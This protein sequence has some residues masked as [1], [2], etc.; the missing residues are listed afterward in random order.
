MSWR[1]AAASAIGTSHANAGIVCQD[2]V[3]A[4]VISTPGDIVFICAVSDGA[5][6]AQYA[7]VGSKTAVDTAIRLVET[8][9]KT[10]GAVSEATRELA[11]SWFA[12]V[13]RSILKMAEEFGSSIREFGCTLLVAIIAEE[14][15]AF[16]QVGDGA[17]V[18][19]DGINDN[20]S[21]IFWPQ[22]GEYANSTNFVTSSNFLAVMEFELVNRRIESFASF[23]DGIER[24][25]LHHATKSV[26]APFFNSM[27]IPVEQ[28]SAL[29]LSRS[30][31]ESLA[32]FLNSEAVCERTDD[33]KTLVLATRRVPIKQVSNDD[34]RA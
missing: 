15:A 23:S 19:A 16:I 11:A 27:L 2:S 1:I 31:S 5:G 22:H 14:F 9:L 3:G 25:V 30:G 32:K 7:E 6:S 28:L 20:W 18:V 12:E 33:D 29:G 34:C 10:G 26:Y 21:Y 13:Q 24:L 8:Y 4:Q 17:M